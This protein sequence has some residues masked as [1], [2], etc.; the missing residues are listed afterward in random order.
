M[1]AA[2]LSITSSGNNLNYKYN[3]YEKECNIIMCG[4]DY[5]CM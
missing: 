3:H 4:Y 1:P 5:I 2:T